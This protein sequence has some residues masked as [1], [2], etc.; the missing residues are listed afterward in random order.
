MKKA[1]KTATPPTKANMYPEHKLT[2]AL[3]A[4]VAVEE[5]PAAVAEAS[6]PAATKA[7]PAKASAETA[8]T[9]PGDKKPK[10][11]KQAMLAKIREKKANK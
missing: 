2:D 11:D 1:G 7:A 10:F 9:A 8:A 4:T 3:P 5:A 6:A